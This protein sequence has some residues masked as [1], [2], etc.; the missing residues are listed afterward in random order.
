MKLIDLLEPSLVK[1]RLEPPEGIGAFPEFSYSGSWKEASDP[2]EWSRT[3]GVWE[4]LAQAGFGFEDRPWLVSSGPC[5]FSREI[6]EQIE[7]RASLFSGYLRLTE[8]IIDRKYGGPPTE[9]LGLPYRD[10][11]DYHGATII[12]FDDILTPGGKL[13]MTE[14]EGWSSGQGQIS[15]LSEIYRL[16]SG[17][18][19]LSTSFPGL[20]AVA[21]SVMK[22]TF[23]G[24]AKIGVVVPEIEEE[25]GWKFIAKDFDLFA[26]RCRTLG[27]DMHVE[28][29]S[30]L[31]VSPHGVSG[32]GGH[33]DVLYPF[34]PPSGYA[35]ERVTLG[36]GA[37]ILS[38]WAE[39]NVELFPEPSWLPTKEIMTTVFDPLNEGQYIGGIPNTHYPQDIMPEK[40][41]DKW[42]KWMK[43]LGADADFWDFNSIHLYYHALKSSLFPWS[44]QLD[45][46]RS[47]VLPSGE[48]VSWDE[49][50]STENLR[51]GWVFKPLL[52]TECAGV[53]FSQ[54]A[55]PTQIAQFAQHKLQQFLVAREEPYPKQPSQA[56][57]ADREGVTFENDYRR[58]FVQKQIPHEKFK[59]KYLNP[60][61]TGIRSR[62]GF[63]ARICSTVFIDREGKATVGDVDVTLRKNLR[64]HGATDSI[65]TIA[66]FEES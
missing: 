66:T 54:E 56:S 12:R 58:Y 41:Q 34:F 33:Y 50:L 16:Q 36:K 9:L 25:K 57:R 48:E 31:T 6:A 46:S 14:P 4:L 20:E 63:H 10:R 17:K 61:K 15:A 60:R 11:K 8:E 39:G 24:D 38:A 53:V 47:P 42:Y 43:E 30:S 45:P 26:K 65:V 2:R 21:S 51:K 5:H 28:R 27:V 1:R 40:E 19:G 7:M 13:L 62:D 35:D 55:S 49:F 22:N 3:V 64:V 29:P 18:S 23:G 37:A 32:N 59:A 44:W 52:G